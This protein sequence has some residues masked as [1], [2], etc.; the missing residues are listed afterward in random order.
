MGTVSTTLPSD[1]QTI[2][3][4]DVNTPINAI[5]AEFNGNI[6][7]NN[8]KTGANINGAKLLAGSLPG[9]ALDTTLASGW[10]D[11]A[12]VP[13][14]VTYN[15]NRSYDLVFNSTDLTD[16]VS[17]GMRLRLTRTVSAPTQC[18]DLE[19]GS[20]QYASLASASVTGCTFTTAF[21][22]MAWIKPES[23]TNG[24]II[25]RTD[26]T[27]GWFME[28]QAD[29]TLRVVG[30]AGASIDSGS[31][32]QSVPLNK[33]VHVAVT[34][35][36]VANTVLTYIDGVSVPNT[37]A[38]ATAA[39]VQAGNLQ[40]GARTGGTFF[41]GKIAQAAVFSSVLSAATIR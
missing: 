22:C 20:S 30:D 40:V 26:G 2:D 33:W 37:A 3:S 21:T 36:L 35:D 8:I 25:S 6:D 14:T 10:L 17:E 11:L 1:G 24:A 7:D 19:A 32:Y 29:G 34:M 9:T 39:L 41:D 27:S 31:T 15:G 23:Y 12:D 28:L 38:S 18:T 16:T 13:D 5:L 4:S